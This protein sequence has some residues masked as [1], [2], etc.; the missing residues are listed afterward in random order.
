MCIYDMLCEREVFEDTEVLP[1]CYRIV[2]V[3]SQISCSSI[4]LSHYIY[5][6]RFF[7]YIPNVKW[8]VTISLGGNIL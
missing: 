7:S 5:L 4:A 1:Y 3:K 6:Y 2:T 8:K